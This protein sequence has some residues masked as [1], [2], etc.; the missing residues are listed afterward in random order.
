MAQKELDD[1]YWAGKRLQ[2]ARE[3]AAKNAIGLLDIAE[4]LGLLKDKYRAVEDFYIEY[5]GIVN[6]LCDNILKDICLKQ[7]IKTVERPVQPVVQTGDGDERGTA[8]D[9]QRK[10]VFAIVW[11]RSGNPVLA[12][13]LSVDRE[14]LD[15]ISFEEASE[16]I[17]KH[18]KNKTITK[19]IV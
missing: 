15:L 4:R 18:G 19:N 9:N 1:V 14:N 11:G 8:T 10:A 13:E 2:E 7:E 16:F 5:N 12:D 6:Q 17:S 3:S